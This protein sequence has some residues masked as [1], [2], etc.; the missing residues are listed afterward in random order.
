MSGGAFRELLEQLDIRSGD[1]VYVHSSYSRLRQLGTVDELLATLLSV[2][3]PRGTAVF[4]SFAWNLDRTARPWKGYADYYRTRPVFDVCETPTN[5]GWLAE[6]FRV[7]PEVRRSLSY[8]WSIAAR[9]PLAELLTDGQLHVT[10]PFGE[11]SSFDLLRQHGAKI[12]GLGVTL[13]T[14]SLAPLVDYA[15]GERHPHAVFGE[16]PEAGDIVDNA[17][18]RHRSWTYFLLPDVVR[19]IKPSVV[20][21]T[22]SALHAVVRRADQGETI[23]FAYPFAEYYSV[24]LEH[25]RHAATADAAVPWLEAYPRRAH[26][27]L[28]A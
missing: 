7:L 1:L 4:P 15:L 13:N 5:I 14:S 28:R 6:R 12:V 21:D 25:G 27:A 9:G 17:G 23:Y 11:R 16:A 3:G 24:A 22:S 2:L 19:L 20:F 26:Q 8:C 18:Q 10:H